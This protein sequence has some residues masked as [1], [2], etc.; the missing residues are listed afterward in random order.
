MVGCLVESGAVMSAH[1]WQLLA[2]CAVGVAYFA[3]RYRVI[4]WWHNR[5]PFGKAM[6]RLIDA[7]KKALE[8][9]GGKQ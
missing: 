9:I 2:I 3:A 8:S 5:D 1:A 7:D 4:R 6:R